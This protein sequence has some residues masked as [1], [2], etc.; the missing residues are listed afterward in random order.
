MVYLSERWHSY[1]ILAQHTSMIIFY[2]SW[3]VYIVKL[4][5]SGVRD[6]RVRPHASDQ[7]L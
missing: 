5:F 3:L 6:V 4:A 7:A 2:V 1:T